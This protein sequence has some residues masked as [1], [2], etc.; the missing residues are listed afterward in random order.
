MKKITFLGLVTLL[1]MLF[2]TTMSYS[3]VTIYNDQGTCPD[4]NC[5]SNAIEINRVYL[6][7]GA[8]LELDDVCANIELGDVWVWVDIQ[9]N[10]NS[11]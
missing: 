11:K 1:V 4:G 2:S 7:D 5:T 6:G 9:A 8:G 10:S 3:Q